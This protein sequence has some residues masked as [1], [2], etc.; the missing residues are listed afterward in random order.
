[1]TT[2]Q[3][4]IRTIRPKSFTTCTKMNCVERENKG[5]IK[6][7]CINCRDKTACMNES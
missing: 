3:K 5:N 7:S 6:I 1:M 4:I 2:K